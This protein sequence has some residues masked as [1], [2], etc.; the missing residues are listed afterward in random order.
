MVGG[1][2]SKLILSGVGQD[3]LR[4]EGLSAEVA[5]WEDGRRTDDGPGAF[6]WW[7]F[8][9]HFE[10]G[11]IAVVSLAIQPRMAGGSRLSPLVLLTI[12]RSDGSRIISSPQVASQA[13]FEVSKDGGSVRIGPGRPTDFLR[14][15]AFH[16][17]GEG[18][19]AADLVFTRLAPSWQPDT[20][21]RYSDP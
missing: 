14:R 3:L 1:D 21:K 11:V 19:I 8:D 12:L 15:Y 16:C 17:R 20:G 9:A 10:N 6:R 18:R 5:V 13:K 2:V 4:R 7:F